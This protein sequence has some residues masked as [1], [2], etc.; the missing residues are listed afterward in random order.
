LPGAGYLISYD[1]PVGV[2]RELIA[3]CGRPAPTTLALNQRTAENSE[4]TR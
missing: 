3:F 4:R 1:D 2:A